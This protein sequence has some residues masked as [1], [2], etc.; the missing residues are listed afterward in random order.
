MNVKKYEIELVENLA[1]EKMSDICDDLTIKF[2][3]ALRNHKKNKSN[4]YASISDY[5]YKK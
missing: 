2:K 5:L 1:I 4:I 3:S